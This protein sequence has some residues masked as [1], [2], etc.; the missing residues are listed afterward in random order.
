PG[1]AGGNIFIIYLKNAEAARVA[2]TLRALLAGGSDTSGGQSAP[3]LAPTTSLNVSA[4]TTAGATTL[5]AAPISA[6]VSSTGG[7]AFSAGGAT[8]QA[9]TANNALIVMAPEPVYNNIRAVV[10][11]LDIRRAQVY[12]E[13]LI[14]EVSADQ[15][16]EFGIQWNLLNPN[17][18]KNNSTQVAGGTNFGTRATGTN[19][20]YE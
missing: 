18:F 2:Q 3:S 11:K 20:F 10:E 19:I 1:R 15:V 14:A 4:L 17:S 8:I 16:G 7:S 12:V 9:D 5:V 6:P 13:A